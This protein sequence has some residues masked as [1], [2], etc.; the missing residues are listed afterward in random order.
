MYLQSFVTKS[1]TF[2]CTPSLFIF[3]SSNSCLGTY[4]ACISILLTLSSLTCFRSLWSALRS[5]NLVRDISWAICLSYTFC[6]NW[7]NYSVRSVW[8]SL[9]TC[10]T[11]LRSTLLDNCST[12]C[13]FRP[14]ISFKLH[15]SIISFFRFSTSRV[16]LSRSLLISPFWESIS[17]LMKS[18]VSSMSRL[19]SSLKSLICSLSEYISSRARSPLI[20]TFSSFSCYLLSLAALSMFRSF[21]MIS[22]YCDNSCLFWAILC[23]KCSLS[24]FLAT[25]SF[26]LSIMLKSAFLFR[27]ATM[28]FFKAPISFCIVSINSSMSLS[29]FLS[30]VSASSLWLLNYT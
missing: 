13:C 18:A 22:S 15:L 3:S 7:V 8:H 28:L 23:L 29:L 26:N 21:F 1:W 24:T 4:W 19:R 27:L 6:L 16:V 20:S 25:Y 10:W 9:R 5:I 14:S 12:S 17:D 2:L 30:L 11:S